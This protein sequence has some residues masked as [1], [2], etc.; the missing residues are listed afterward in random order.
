MARPAL[1]SPD[2]SQHS[3]CLYRLGQH[4]GVPMTVLADRLIRYGLKNLGHVMPEQPAGEVPGITP[5]AETPEP[6]GGS[7]IKR[8]AA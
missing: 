6:C 2:I 1:Y 4:Y 7:S 8:K 3:R 5:V